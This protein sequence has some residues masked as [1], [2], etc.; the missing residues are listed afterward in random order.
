MKVKQNRLA[1][2]LHH[3]MRLWWRGLQGK[4]FLIIMPIFV[5]IPM[6]VLSILLPSLDFRSDLLLVPL[7]EKFLWL[8]VGA[9][10]LLFFSAFTFAM[11]QS[12]F[13]LFDRGD[14]DL[15]I[16]SPIPSK[17]IFA[18]RL[19]TVAIDI[20]LSISL[21]LILPSLI[22][23]MLGFIRLL[24][25]YPTLMAIC[26]TATSLAM[27][28]TLW[29]VWLIGAKRARILNQVLTSLLW[30]GFIIV[31]QL[32]N[33]RVFKNVDSEQFWNSWAGLFMGEGS[34]LSAKSW[35][36]FPARAIFFDP[37][38]MLLTF[39]ISGAI[40]W[41]TV[42]KLHHTFLNGTQQS[43]TIKQNKPSS[44][45]INRF[46]DSLSQVLL[47]KEWRIIARN[48]YLLLQ[49]FFSIIFLIPVS[50]MML[51]DTAFQDTAFEGFNSLDTIVLI[52]SLGAGNNLTTQLALICI[53]GEEAPDLLRSCPC[54]DIKLRRWKL[55][56]VLIPVWLLL[57][58]LFVILMIRGEAWFAP[59]MVFI[60][61]TICCAF[62]SLWSASPIALSSLSMQQRQKVKT[63]P[64]LGF[65]NFISI[66]LWLFLGFQVSQEN[67]ILILIGISFIALLMSIAYKRSRLI[68]S[69]LGF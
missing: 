63:D 47:L 58:P 11:G 62:L 16:S 24:G 39:L 3:E 20:F 18:S 8:A 54:K 45:S 48:P 19:I 22:A 41:L 51:Q 32:P 65:L 5:I 28:I 4:W 52:A 27:L 15:L 37:V 44:I 49:S 6:L 10:L 46:K 1:W 17:V 68:G 29:L 21:F 64:I 60:G 34:I 61:A 31:L 30:T 2:L 25:I 56:A 69:S 53:S 42:E 12:L 55:M 59:M 38:A 43:L 57:S 66:F 67:I 23:V 36:W 35:I 33:L 14:L 13:A 26:L 7:I 40:F 9:Y 50:I